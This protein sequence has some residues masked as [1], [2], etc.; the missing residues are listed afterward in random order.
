MSKARLFPT[1][2]ES[3]IR[4]GGR[5]ERTETPL[6]RLVR[7]ERLLISRGLC[8]FEYIA[9]IPTGNRISVT[10]ALE[11]AAKARSPFSS[12]RVRLVWG[13][14][15]IGVWTWPSDDLDGDIKEALQIP[16][17]LF[18]TAVE[19]PV[20][21]VCSDGYE[22]QIW[23]NEEMIA[24]RWWSSLPSAKAWDGF[25]RSS[26]SGDAI[27]LPTPS[28]PDRVTAP[29]PPASRTLEISSRLSW[30]DAAAAACLIMAAFGYL[31]GQWVNLEL[32]IRHAQAQ[33]SDLEE[34]SAEVLA[35]RQRAAELTQRIDLANAALS[36]QH[37]LLS[38]ADMTETLG[39]HDSQFESY[40]SRDGNVEALVPAGAEVQIAELVAA[41]EASTHLADVSAEATNRPGEYRI[42]ASSASDD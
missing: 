29:P 27:S 5:V 18:H 20:L 30:K 3:R 17:S 35:A 4:L 7:G 33:I 42:T 38:L 22:G 13:Q 25:L 26:W 19:G 8:H 24:S 37:P 14:I 23:D 36:A 15:G 32:S 12:P 16:E 1:P 6:A 9:K 21:R 39:E 11:L 2:V 10:R 34:A 31:S 40:L 28:R 41:L